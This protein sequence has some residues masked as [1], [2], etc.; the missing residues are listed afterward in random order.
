MV[1]NFS[2]RLDILHGLTGTIRSNSEELQE[3][4]GVARS[5]EEEENLPVIETI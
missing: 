3:N 5:L 4:V 1:M 2:L